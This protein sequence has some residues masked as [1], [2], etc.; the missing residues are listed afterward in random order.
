[1]SASNR[2]PIEIAGITPR[3]A[4]F[5]NG[6]TAVDDRLQRS[7]STDSGRVLKLSPQAHGGERVDQGV[8]LL[9]AVHVRF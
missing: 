5:C 3:I 7:A 1:M 8:Q 4:S 6:G 9:E 2:N